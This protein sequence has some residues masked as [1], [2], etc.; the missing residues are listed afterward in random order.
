MPLT[1]TPA[2]FLAALALDF[3]VAGLAS[4][5]SSGK[6]SAGKWAGCGLAIAAGIYLR[7]DG[8]ILLIAIGGCLLWRLA[9]RGQ[10]R[11]TLW[12]GVVLGLCSLL[13]LAPWTLRNWRVF[14]QFMPL[15]PTHANAPG[16]YYAAGFDRWMRTWLA[17]YAS[18]E[19]IGFRI[20]S[21]EIDVHLLPNR[22]FD[23]PAER[24]RTEELFERHNE[25]VT[26]TPELDAQFDQLARQR[27]QRKP[28]RYYVELPVLRMVD[29]WLRPRTAMLPLDAHWW[30]FRDD[31]RD[32]AWSLLLAAIN[33]AYVGLGLLGAVLSWREIGY[34]G[35]LVGFVILRTVIM[36]VL[37]FPEPRYVLE[38]Y[39]V[40]IVFAAAALLKCNSV[41]R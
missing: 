30:K 17:D 37:V 41:T 40:V 31:P 4:Q 20:D 24:S 23:T 15:A 27:I 14:H 2:I 8:G 28:F 9:W 6:V 22:A 35:M 34:A 5:E 18:L 16:E 11:L 38:C 1:E 12:A 3:A 7:P 25:T 19:D 13:P 39:P 10:R 29:L 33:A 32:F 21:E 26:M 36:T